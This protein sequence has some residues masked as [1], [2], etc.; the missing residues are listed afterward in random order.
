MHWKY[1]AAVSRTPTCKVNEAAYS[2]LSLSSMPEQSQ[3]KGQASV[4]APKD[5]VVVVV[6]D[7]ELLEILL[8]AVVSVA[9]DAAFVEWHFSQSGLVRHSK[10]LL[11]VNRHRLLTR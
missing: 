8:E 10:N 5:E 3:K 11:L 7:A 1:L 4:G 9:K 6:L 2:S